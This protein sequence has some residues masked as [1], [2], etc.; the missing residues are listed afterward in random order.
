MSFLTLSINQFNCCHKVLRMFCVN[1]CCFIFSANSRQTVPDKA[2][3][4][5]IASS[6]SAGDIQYR[7]KPPVS[8]VNMEHKVIKL[9]SS[10]TTSS[11]KDVADV[12]KSQQLK[13]IAVTESSF[14]STSCGDSS[15]TPS[16]KIRLCQ[17]GNATAVEKPQQ[18]QTVGDVSAGIVHAKRTSDYTGETE[19]KKFKANAITWP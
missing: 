10:K 14:V 15:A 18:H 17:P 19:K 7:L 2:G 12:Q 1:L 5:R 13:P 11:S 6:S 3:S 8:A 16:R 4:S 9:T